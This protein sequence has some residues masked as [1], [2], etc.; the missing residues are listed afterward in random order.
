MT[1]FRN[2]QN[3]YGQESCGSIEIDRLEKLRDDLKKVLPDEIQSVKD[4]K[5]FIELLKKFREAVARVDKLMVI[6]IP[7]F[8]IRFYPLVKMVFIPTTSDLYLNLFKTWMT[9]IIAAV[10]IASLI[11]VLILKMMKSF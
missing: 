2:L 3:E 4:G 5:S 10:L 9:A 8:L 11:C 1:V 7:S 6:T